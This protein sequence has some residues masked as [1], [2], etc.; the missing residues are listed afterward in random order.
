VCSSDLNISSDPIYEQI[1]GQVKVAIFSGDL[2][3]DSVLPSIRTLAAN[4]K[5]SVITAMR[6]YQDLEEEGFVTSVHGKGYY[7]LPQNKEVSRE[8]ALL[9]IEE[10][11]TEALAI[12]KANHIKRKEICEMV[13]VLSKH[14]KTRRKHNV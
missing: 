12:A 13:N 14:K 4:L 2:E 8:N 6:A 11:L 7:V 9:R 5:V 1:K 3:P 10:K